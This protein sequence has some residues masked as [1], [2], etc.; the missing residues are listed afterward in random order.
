MVY[1]KSIVYITYNF[2]ENKVG[3]KFFWSPISSFLLVFD[4]TSRNFT[5]IVENILNKFWLWLNNHYCNKICEYNLLLK[6]TAMWDRF[7]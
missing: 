6:K 2:Q 5:A 3:D 7:S 1:A 4:I